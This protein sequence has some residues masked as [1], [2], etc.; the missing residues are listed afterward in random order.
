MG[1]F[2][3]IG[4][5]RVGHVAG[6]AAAVIGSLTSLVSTVV[7]TAIGRLYDGTVIPL[8]GGLFAMTLAAI[9]VTRVGRAG[10]IAGD[11]PAPS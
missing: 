11:A 8:T 2:K 6:S 10:D 3:D 9:L 4:V 1:P 7:G 5:E